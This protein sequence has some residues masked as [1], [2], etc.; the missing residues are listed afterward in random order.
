MTEPITPAAQGAEVSFREVTKTYRSPGG[1]AVTA[2]DSVTLEV[3]PGESVAVM[4][5]SGSGKSTLLHLAG[6]MDLPD[7][8]QIVIGG[9]TTNTMNEKQRAAMRRNIGF[10]FQRFHL[11][12]ALSAVDN[13]TAPL[14][15]FKVAFDK[16]AGAVELLDAVGLGHRKDHIPSRLSGGEQQRVAIARALI[17]RPG[18]LLADEPTGNLDT[19]TGD[20]IVDLL[21]QL[22]AERGITIIIATHAPDLA[23]RCS[24]TITI[25]NGQAHEQN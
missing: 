24:R 2:L 6:L 7:T 20:Q 8:G 12:P 9:R 3:A 13:V 19:D 1:I 5:P 4:G 21:L 16:H 23:A 11:L 15:P 25:R 22:H 18:L 10:V 14:L 17:N